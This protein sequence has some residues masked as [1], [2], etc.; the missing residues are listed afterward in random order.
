M[1]PS[2]RMRLL[3]PGPVTLTDEV[4]EAQ[5]GPDLCHRQPEYMALQDE[6]RQR[7]QTV[8]SDAAAEYTAVLITGSGTAAVECMVDSLVP[9]SGRALVVA[10]GVYG[11]RIASI[12]SIHE[13]PFEVVSSQWTEPMDLTA[14]E[15]RLAANP[16]ITHVIAVHHETTTGRLNDVA[17]LGQLCRQHRVPL[18][19]DTVSSFG[20]ELLRFADWNIQAC[21]ATANKCL[22]GVPGTAFVLVRHDALEDQK[23][24]ATSL[25]L[26]LFRHWSSQQQGSTQFTPAVQSMYALREALSELEANGGWR[27]RHAHYTALS[28]RL[29][30]QLLDLGFRLLLEDESV[31]AATLTSFNLPFGVS[32][33]RLYS[34]MIEHGFV[35]YPG[36]KELQTKI[37]RIAVMGDLSSSDIDEFA[38]GVEGVTRPVRERHQ[39]VVLH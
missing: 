23:S 19:L 1:L 9:R 10:N 7:L 39:P 12:L 17:S 20:G 18:L 16:A 35:I 25:Y 21:A 31:Y 8:Y 33:D 13:K 5:L 38:M 27:T 34:E 37:F 32:F 4:R 24:A 28:S 36:Q 26:D 2:R 6:V 22:H 15:R 29:R 14:V 11:E 3:N 30:R